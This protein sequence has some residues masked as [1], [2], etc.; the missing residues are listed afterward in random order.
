MNLTLQN[1]E[2]SL[3]HSTL[4]NLDTIKIEDS[5]FWAPDDDVIQTVSLIN[6]TITLDV[7][8]SGI[9]NDI[10]LNFLHI[11]P[12]HFNIHID[13]N[14]FI[15]MQE[16]EKAFVDVKF[17]NEGELFILDNTFEN[18]SSH[19]Y[20]IR[21]E[22]DDSVFLNHTKFENWQTFEN[23]F[24]S[25]DLSPMIYVNDLVITGAQHVGK[26]GVEGTLLH[27]SVCV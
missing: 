2:I 9:Y 26:S 13:Q 18:W 19:E 24:L 7:D 17:D 27:F 20:A 3:H 10:K 21:I 23:G 15:N 25:V 14:K 22:T 12:R 1:S 6:N 11:A 16:S 4:E 8:Q 5:P